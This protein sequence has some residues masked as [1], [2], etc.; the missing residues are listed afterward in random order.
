MN[1]LSFGDLRERTGLSEPKIR[2]YL[3]RESITPI[4][5]FAGSFVYSSDTPERVLKAA[6]GADTNSG[7]LRAVPRRL[8]VLS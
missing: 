1:G 6:A 5:V 7:M 4:G 8:D 3:R 2:Y